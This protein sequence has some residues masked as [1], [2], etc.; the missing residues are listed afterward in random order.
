MWHQGSKGWD[1]GSEGW[2]LGSQP[3]DQGSQPMGSGPAVFYRD[4]GLGC[5]TF[6]GSGTKINH[7]FGIKE[8]KFAYKMGSAMKKHTSL[9][10][11]YPDQKTLNIMNVFKDTY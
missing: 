5:T 1:W 9:P 2:D 7:A 8:R 6:V 10:P 4:Q 3:W 11:C